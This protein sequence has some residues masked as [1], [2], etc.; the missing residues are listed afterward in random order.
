MANGFTSTNV[1]VI[2][3]SSDDNFIGHA[4]DIYSWYDLMIVEMAQ[5][6]SFRIVKRCISWHRS[7]YYIC[8]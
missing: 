4:G 3:H 8:I 5:E 7:R 2:R 1:E 6:D